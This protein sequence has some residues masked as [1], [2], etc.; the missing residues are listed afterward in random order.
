VAALN[1]PADEASAAVFLRV[2]RDALFAARAPPT[3]CCRAPAGDLLPEPAAPG[4]STRR[5]LQT[6]RRACRRA[7]PMAAGWRS[8]A[9]LRR[10]GAGLQPP[11]RPRG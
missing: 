10:R 6:G 11:P 1:T 3:C 4:C 2:L 8:T 5:R 9:S 7:A